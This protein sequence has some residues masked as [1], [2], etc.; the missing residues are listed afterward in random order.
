MND[1][2]KWNK[3]PRKTRIKFRSELFSVYAEVTKMVPV[4]GDPS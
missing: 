3:K 2:V 1:H 4:K